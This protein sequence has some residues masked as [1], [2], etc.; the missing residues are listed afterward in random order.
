MN[1]MQSILENPVLTGKSLFLMG[2][3]NVNVLQ[4]NENNHVD[5]FL[6][7]LMSFSLLPLITKPTRVTET[8][9]TLIDNIFSNS[10][11]FP[12]SGIII[13]DLSDHVPV[14]TKVG[15]GKLNSPV[16]HHKNIRKS[17]PENIAKFR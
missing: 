17:D 11:H 8:T 3:Y 16:I 7:M 10:R 13:S 14:Y 2:D 9:S 4:C 6:N 1:E 12:S 5:D 15:W